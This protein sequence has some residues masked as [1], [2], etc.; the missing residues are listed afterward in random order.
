MV[1]LFT[2]HTSKFWIQYLGNHTDS[3]IY[4]RNDKKN[5]SAYDTANIYYIYIYIYIYIYVSFLENSSIFSHFFQIFLVLLGQSLTQKKLH[6][7]LQLILVVF[8]LLRAVKPFLI[9]V[10]KDV[11]CISPMLTALRKIIT[12]NPLLEAILGYFL[13]CLVVFFSIPWKSF[14][15]QALCLIHFFFS[16]AVPLHLVIV[17]IIVHSHWYHH[18]YKKTSKDQ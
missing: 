16:L 11:F 18:N 13:V 17:I 12:A 5:T 3:M 6:S 9:K 15:F 2:N 1:A 14:G 10:F 7:F 8:H 4:L